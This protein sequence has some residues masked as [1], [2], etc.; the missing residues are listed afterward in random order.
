MNG[1]AETDDLWVITNGLNQGVSKMVSE[2]VSNLRASSG[3]GDYAI[4]V[5]GI[6]PYEV[7]KAKQLISS[8][9]STES[10]SWLDQD[11]L[12]G[13]HNEFSNF[14]DVVKLAEKGSSTDL[15]DSALAKILKVKQK[16][17]HNSDGFRSPLPVSE[18]GFKEATHLCREPDGLGGFLWDS[19]PYVGPRKKTKKNVDDNGVSR[20]TYPSHIPK[21]IDKHHTHF[22]FVKTFVCNSC[23]REAIDGTG[24]CTDHQEAQTGENEWNRRMWR[25]TMKVRD[26][27][28][29][30]L[31]GQH[32]I[33]LLQLHEQVQERRAQM[34]EIIKTGTVGQMGAHNFHGG[35]V[36]GK[37]DESKTILVRVS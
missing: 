25:D 29:D 33:D 34:E 37:S 15:E 17:C 19:K 16:E 35:D 28:E 27:L 10:K 23:T 31:K 11:L 5:I 2:I 18:D 30:Y 26:A 32:F 6:L 3:L 7:L 1:F 14:E 21:D 8:K 24:F 36:S 4:P 12:P 13:W 22:I 9:P 20:V